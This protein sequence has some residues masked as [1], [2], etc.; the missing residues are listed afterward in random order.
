MR[1]WL[2]HSQEKSPPLPS[3]TEGLRFPRAIAGL[4]GQPEPADAS[5]GALPACG[6]ARRRRNGARVE[7]PGRLPTR[8]TRAERDGDLA[9]RRAARARH[10]RTVLAGD[11]PRLRQLRRPGLRHRESQRAAR[12]RRRHGA[13]GLHHHGGEQLVSADPSLP[14][15]RLRAV[16]PERRRPPPGERGHPPAERAG[17]V[18]H[19]DPYDGRSMVE[20]LRRGALRSPSSPRRVGRL[21]CRAQ[22]RVEHALRAPRRSRL[23]RM[24]LVAQGLALSPG[25]PA[26][27][28]RPDVE[29]DGRDTPRRSPAARLL[30]ASPDTHPSAAS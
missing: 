11:P 10:A 29:A 30:A 13:M 28:A 9:R 23:R 3:T 16:R 18:R 21:G 7:A 24:G 25:V 5:A 22:G 12:P 14:R 20:R 26:L 19:P 15:P 8:T 6:P 17:A 2:A 4:G 1:R 27:R